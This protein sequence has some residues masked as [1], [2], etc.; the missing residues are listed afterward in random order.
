MSIPLLDFFLIFIGSGLGG[1]SRY[2][3]AHLSSVKIAL[4]FPL[5]TLFI[6][7]CGSFLIGF[8]SIIIFSRISLLSSHLRAFLLIGFLGGFTTYSTFALETV[9][10]FVD[11]EITYGL[12]NILLSASLSIIMAWAGVILGRMI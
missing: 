9:N 8:L 11:R 5:G 7:V 1:V 12:L 6:N 4:Q 3:I 10:L 2:L